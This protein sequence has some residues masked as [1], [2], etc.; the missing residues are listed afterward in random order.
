MISLPYDHPEYGE[1]ELQIDYSLH[2][3]ADSVQVQFVGSGGDI[4]EREQ[5][6]TQQIA[7]KL[8][9]P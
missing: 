1:V 3:G 8:L 4:I 6:T 2:I 5:Y 9:S 7:E